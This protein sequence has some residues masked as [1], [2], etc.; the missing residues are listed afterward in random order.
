[1]GELPIDAE[2]GVRFTLPAILKPRYMPEGSVDPLVPAAGTKKG[3]ASAVYDFK[4]TLK[5]DEVA[6]VTSPTHAIS[7]DKDADKVCVSLSG[8]D[9]QPLKK[10]LVV[11]ISHKDPHVP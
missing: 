8:E 4:M 6:D 10:A 2:G 3:E 11:L 1:M 7:V 5:S 9:A